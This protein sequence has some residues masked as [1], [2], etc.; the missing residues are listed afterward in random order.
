[1]KS[2]LNLPHEL[3]TSIDVM[4]TLNGGI[5][6]PVIRVKKLANQHRITLRVPGLPVDSIKI[7]IK[8]NQLVIYYL[9]TL[10]SQEQEIQFTR[11]LYTNAIPYFVDVKNIAATEENGSLVVS[12]PFNDLSK[13]Y[14]RDLSIQK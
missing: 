6:E 10:R 2:A 3:I 4:N 1:M 12:L 13:G 11:F 14:Y 8:N 7:E 9:M 5:S